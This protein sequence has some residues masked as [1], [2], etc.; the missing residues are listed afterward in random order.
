ME[1]ENR[2]GNEESDPFEK[3]RCYVLSIKMYLC[4]A[5]P[6]NKIRPRAKLPRVLGLFLGE[7]WETWPYTRNK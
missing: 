4:L 2:L 5:D 6:R 7:R 3:F 1:K